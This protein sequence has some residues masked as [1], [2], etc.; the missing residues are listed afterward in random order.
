MFSVFSLYID[1]TRKNVQ[2]EKFKKNQIVIR[3]NYYFTTFFSVKLSQ[4]WPS[5]SVI[6][7]S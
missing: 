2:Q 6:E 1:L 4:Q 5:F 7:K 3:H